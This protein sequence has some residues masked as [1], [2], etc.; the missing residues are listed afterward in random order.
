[1]AGLIPVAIP[2]RNAETPREKAIGNPQAIIRRKEPSRI[3]GGDIT[4]SPLS[5]R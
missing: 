5:A 4:A 1:M 3:S 2:V